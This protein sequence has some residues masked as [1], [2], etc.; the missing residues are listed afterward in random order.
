MT[1]TDTA[2]TD[3]P[4][5]DF[6]GAQSTLDSELIRHLGFLPGLAELLMV[7]QV[8]ALEHATVWVLSEPVAGRPRSADNTALGGLSTER[9]FYLYGNVT[10]AR[11]ERAVC[12][13]LRRFYSG[14]WDLAVHPRCG[15]NL[16][17][18]ALLAAGLGLGAHAI[19]PRGPLEQLFGLGAAAIAAAQL[20]PELGSL[21]QRYLTTAVPFDLELDAIWKTSDFGKRPAHFVRLR[22]R[23][24]ETKFRSSDRLR[25][26]TGRQAGI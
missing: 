2:R 13:A 5:F 21:V 24:A 16:A 10:H 11:L 9:G 22:W 6:W 14:E 19:L 23:D 20:A 26:A 8:H 7:R 17:V 25:A 12:A 18:T 1:H 3:V 15:T 4:R